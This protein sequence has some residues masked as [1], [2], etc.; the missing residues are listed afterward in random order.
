MVD[1]RLGS[2]AVRLRGNGPV[3]VLWHNLFVDDNLEQGRGG[4]RPRAKT[5]QGAAAPKLAPKYWKP[6]GCLYD[7]CFILTCGCIESTSA[8]PSAAR[9]THARLRRT[10]HRRM[11]HHA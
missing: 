2:L 4:L 3:A 11:G 7:I 9:S 5:D 10:H 1:T 6:L 8:A